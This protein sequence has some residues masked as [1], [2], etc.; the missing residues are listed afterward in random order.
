MSEKIIQQLILIFYMQKKKKYIQ[1]TFQNTTQIVKTNYSFNNL[2][3]R[4]MIALSCGKKY[5]CY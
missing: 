2:K 4:M 5:L 3:Q 1:S